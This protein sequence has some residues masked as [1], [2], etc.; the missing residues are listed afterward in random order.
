MHVSKVRIG[1]AASVVLVLVAAA[2]LLGYLRWS[3]GTPPHIAVL[4]D[5]FANAVGADEVDEGYPRRLADQLALDVVTFAQGG[6]GYT[7]PGQVEQ[8]ETTF[9]GRV[10]ELAAVHP[11]LVVVQGSLNDRERPA[12]EVQ[13]AAEFTLRT[14][15][16]S[17]PD[18]TI[19][20]VGPAPTYAIPAV[21]P[22]P[23]QRAASG[24]GAVFLDSTGWVPPADAANWAGDG[25]HPSSEGHRLL[26]ERLAAELAGR[27]L[28]PAAS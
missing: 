19:V 15:R 14:I 16:V 22:S 9:V 17:M 1:L 3:S 12:P 11:R 4:G 28:I 18:A 24:V 27:G 21:D 26:A 7:N 13:A 6:T 25:V 20:A 8:G 5:S 10:G 23:V 2:A